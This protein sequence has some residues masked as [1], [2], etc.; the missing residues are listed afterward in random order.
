[1]DQIKVFFEESIG[2]LVPQ[3]D[4][5]LNLIEDYVEKLLKGVRYFYV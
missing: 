1:M 4:K 3:Y 2:K 5:F